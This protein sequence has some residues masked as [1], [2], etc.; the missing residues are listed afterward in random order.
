M[1]MLEGRSILITGAAS[2]IGA[3]AASVFSGYGAMLTLI[4]RDDAGARNVAERLPNAIA[5]A[6]DVRNFDDMRRAV[7]A[8]QAQFGAL[9]GAFN[10]AGVEQAGG[11]MTPLAEID[12]EDFDRV[13]AVNLKGAYVSMRAEIPALLAVGGGAIVN[14]ASVMGW[15]GA[16]GLGAYTASKHGVVGLTR[17]VALELAPHGFVGAVGVVVE[18]IFE[19]GERDG[20]PRG[21]QHVH[22]IEEALEAVHGGASVALDAWR[23]RAAGVS[24]NI[25]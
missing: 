9:H 3:A 22:E 14:T 10:N 18:T 4:D 16:P 24:P 1:A 13:I 5:L 15:L 23:P 19:L 21:L 7:A 25:S 6:A 12:P 11:A 17:T 2:G 20:A 8:A